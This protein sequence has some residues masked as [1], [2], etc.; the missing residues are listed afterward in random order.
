MTIQ[1]N[2]VRSTH[3][4]LFFKKRTSAPKVRANEIKDT[5]VLSKEIIVS[6]YFS[7]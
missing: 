4:Y 6:K 3:S 1:T 7:H 5:Y 2:N